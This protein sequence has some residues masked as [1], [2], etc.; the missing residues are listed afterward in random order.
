MA[1]NR[2]YSGPVTDHF[3]GT[4]FFN[5][6]HPSTDR[7]GRDIWR[8]MRER[9][10][11]KWPAQVA[12]VPDKPSPRVDTL[13][14]TMVGH[15]TLLIQVDGLNILTDPVW[16]KRASPLSFAGPSRVTPPG[17][18][19]DDL[20]PIDAVLISHN[21]YDHLDVATLR[22]L[23]DAFAPRLFTPLGNDR[24]LRAAL[25]SAEIWTGDWYE[26]VA[27]GAAARLTVT[28]AHHWSSRTIKDRR[29]ALWGGF[30]LQT[31]AG[32]VWFAGDT[33]YGDGAIF[34]AM[35]GK[36]GSPDVALIPIGA[37]EPRW[38]MADQHTDPEDAVRILQDIGA[39]H[40]LGIHWSTFQ[41]TD[42]G[43]EAPAAELQQALSRRDLPFEMFKAAIVGE[44]Y[45][46]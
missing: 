36:L 24:I 3:D 41:L 45:E 46:F 34:R 29:M 13:R 30:H 39:R 7:S 10:R 1:K 43:R 23:H 37:Y 31:K 44:R 33:G 22:R 14:I 5:P 9:N 6:D 15:A 18:A 35:R 20:P 28:P 16:S 11:T 2:Y 26:S 17:I 12:I 25:P 19:F 38:F 21:H 4:R 42:E 40:A 27:L 32:A 8:W